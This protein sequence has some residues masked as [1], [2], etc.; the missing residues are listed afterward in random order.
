MKMSFFFIHNQNPE[1]FKNC[2][3]YIIPLMNVDFGYLDIIL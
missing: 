3:K 2:N 1:A